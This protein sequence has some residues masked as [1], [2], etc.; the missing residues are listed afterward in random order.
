MREMTTVG[1]YRKTVNM[2]AEMSKKTDRMKE[3]AEKTE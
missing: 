2:G 3:E 1:E